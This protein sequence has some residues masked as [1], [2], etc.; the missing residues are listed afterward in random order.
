MTIFVV[1][2]FIMGFLFGARLIEYNNQN[3]KS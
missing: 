2:A 1:I 3:R